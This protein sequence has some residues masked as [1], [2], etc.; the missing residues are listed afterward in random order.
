M[1]RPEVINWLLGH[2]EYWQHP[3]LDL[4]RLMREAGLI[5]RKTSC[6]DVKTD[7]LIREARIQCG[8]II[9]QKGPVSEEHYHKCPDCGGTPVCY[10]VRCPYP[11]EVQCEAC[12][13][14]AVI[15]RKECRFELEPMHCAKCG[16]PVIGLG[17][18]DD[19]AYC[20]LHT[21]VGD[22]GGRADYDEVLSPKGGSRSG[23]RRTHV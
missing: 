12:K 20:R 21:I 19:I 4:F 5:S 8:E 9:P 1:N 16:A 18:C 22:D 2:R 7:K 6:W 13:Y 3:S 15:D 23:Y 17:T 14:G 10:T 11:K